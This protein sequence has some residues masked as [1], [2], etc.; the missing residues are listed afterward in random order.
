MLK[1]LKEYADA[2]VQILPPHLLVGATEFIS[3][4]ISYLRGFCKGIEIRASEMLG[5]K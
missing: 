3:D 5:M 1:E 4:E 2:W